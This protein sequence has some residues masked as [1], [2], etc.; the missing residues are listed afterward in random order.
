MTSN[1]RMKFP[2]G[3]WKGLR[4]LGIAPHEVARKAGLPL[5]IFNDKSVTISQYLSI[6]QAYSDIIGDTAK[7]IIK[8][9]TG[10]ETVHY[11][12]NCFGSLS[13]SGLSWCTATH[14]QI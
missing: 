5:N 7:G 10:I 13:R 9:T 1:T 11:P 3:F 6:W 2:V 8:L 12:P 4:Q 14:V